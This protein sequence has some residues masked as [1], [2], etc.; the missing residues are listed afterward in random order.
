MT[1]RNASLAW[2]CTVVLASGA[3]TQANAADIA[4]AP[5][6]S[7]WRFTLAPYAWGVGLKGDV[8]LFGLEPAEIDIPFSDILENLDFAAMG[9]AEAH[10]GTWGAFVD[11][12]YTSL[13][14]DKSATGYRQPLGNILE[15][16][17]LKYSVEAELDV[18]EFV[19]TFMGEWRAYDSDQLSL[20]LLAGARYWN[21]QNDI[22]VKVDV[23]GTGPLG[24]SKSKALSG[25]DGAWWIDPMVGAKARI[26]TDT[27]LYFTGWGLI[28]GFGVGSD[29]DWDVM[30][31][32]GY[33]WTEKFSTVLGY[34]AIGVDYDD[35]GFVYDVVQQGVALGLVFNF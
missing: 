22:S 7:E 2:A 33:E 14:A 20:D 17:D 1:F 10:N 30:G 26:D 18:T 15:N 5:D 4:P 29:L 25:S 23:D 13:S 9:I 3:L 34:R 21:V 24:L 35:D 11:I 27:P 28:G 12:N 8:G 16:I 32:I 19:A 6:T 31:G